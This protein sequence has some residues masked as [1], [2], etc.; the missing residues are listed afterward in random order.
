MGP[1]Q[2]GR[3]G[4]LVG[5]GPR[6]GPEPEGQRPLVGR[7]ASRASQA[8]EERVDP[9]E[10]VRPPTH[11]P[12]SASPLM[13]LC[14]QGH[15]GRELTDPRSSGG[16]AERAPPLTLYPKLFFLVEKFILPGVTLRLRVN[17]GALDPRSSGSGGSRGFLAENRACIVKQG[18]AY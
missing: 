6:G 2:V 13:L 5:R 14:V 9:S 18:S 16:P 1:G 3:V 4:P 7:P 15:D 12:Q 17:G 10:Q 11:P 8:A